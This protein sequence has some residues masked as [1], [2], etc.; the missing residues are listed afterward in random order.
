MSNSVVDLCSSD[1]DSD[2]D[3]LFVPHRRM[4]SDTPTGRRR[5]KHAPIRNGTQQTHSGIINID[6]GEDDRKPAARGFGS[7]GGPSGRKKLRRQEIVDMSLN[8]SPPPVLAARLPQS[9]SHTSFSRKLPATKKFV[10]RPKTPRER[11]L[12]V[13]P[14]VETNHLEKILR[15]CKNSAEMVLAIL[16]EGSYPKSKTDGDGGGGDGRRMMAPASVLVKRMQVL[17]K[18]KYDYTSTSSFE[19][20]AIYI[21]EAC[22]MLLFD[23]SFVRVESM[24]KILKEKQQHFTLARNY[25]MKLLKQDRGKNKKR[26]AD[27]LELR[28]FQSFKSVWATKRP[29]QEQKEGIGIQHCMKRFIHRPRPT[30]T[31]P[32]LKDEVQYANHQLESWMQGM[33]E[34]RMRHE[35]R[36]RS[37]CSGN[38]MECGCCFDKVPIEEMVACRNE[39]HLFCID[40]IQSYADTQIF[41][42]GTLGVVKATGQQACELL[43][44]DGSGCQSG[45]YE[46][47]LQRSL[48]VKTLEKYTELQFRASIEAA[49]LSQEMWYVLK[50]HI[51]A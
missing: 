21:D 27:D 51:H 15:D 40:C 32:I 18:P 1:D 22:Q 37:E 4:L 7:L 2:G 23:F 49:G 29:S 14:D 17:V 26:F 11:V 33:E 9:A 5:N 45:F 12:E 36:K 25:I 42:N 3:K 28:E 30:L 44:C 19:P 38:G 41:S 35:A 46:E 48:S 24:R 47:H 34:K 8:S 43:C 39:G 50:V 6:D 16:A 20:T 10:E 31:D 13:F